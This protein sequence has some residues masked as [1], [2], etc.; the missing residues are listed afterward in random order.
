MS[1]KNFIKAIDKIFRHGADIAYKSM[2]QE[3]GI[4]FGRLDEK[5][6]KPLSEPF[7]KVP[8]YK[9]SYDSIQ[10]FKFYEKI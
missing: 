5:T 4:D 10:T 9:N 3:D 8:I 2:V 7:P 1:L 6:K